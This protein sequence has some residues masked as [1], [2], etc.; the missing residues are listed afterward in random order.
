M[1]DGQLGTGS[2]GAVAVCEA[3]PNV[4]Y[5]GMG[6]VPIRGN[7]SHGDGVYK[8]TDGGKIWARIGLQIPGTLVGFA[9]IRRIAMWPMPGFWVISLGHTKSAVCTGRGMGARVGSVWGRFETTAPG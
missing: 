4:I 8:S 9:S 7:V 3:D 5:A 2:V 6:E 1:T